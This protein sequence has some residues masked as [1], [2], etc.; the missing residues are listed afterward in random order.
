[1]TTE[2]LYMNEATGSVDTRDGWYYENED[3]EIVNAVDLGEVL[4]V[5]KDEFGDWVEA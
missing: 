3:G 1:M 2:K 4:E 5:K